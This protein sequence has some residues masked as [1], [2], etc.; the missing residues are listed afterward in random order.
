MESYSVKTRG[1]IY[2]AV[3][4][5]DAVYYKPD[6]TLTER[7]LGTLD[8]VANREP[9]VNQS[10]KRPV[11]EAYTKQWKSTQMSNR[12]SRTTWTNWTSWTRLTGKKV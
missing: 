8:L 2:E 3:A 1:C 7:N 6:P 9:P 5:V 11:R 10:A 12:E 4:K